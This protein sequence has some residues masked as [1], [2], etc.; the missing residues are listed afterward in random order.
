MLVCLAIAVR[1]GLR[2]EVNYNHLKVN[3]SSMGKPKNDMKGTMKD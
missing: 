2:Y 1:K 3:V